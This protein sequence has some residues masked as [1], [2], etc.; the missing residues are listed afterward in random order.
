VLTPV[1]VYGDKHM[2]I[3]LVKTCTFLP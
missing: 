3:K 1:G 2:K